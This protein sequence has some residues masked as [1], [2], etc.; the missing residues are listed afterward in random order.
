MILWWLIIYKHIKIVIF[1]VLLL[2]GNNNTKFGRWLFL[3]SLFTGKNVPTC[4][5]TFYIILTISL[6]PKRPCWK[7][8]HKGRHQYASFILGLIETWMVGT[9]CDSGWL[10]KMDRICEYEEGLK[11]FWYFHSWG[12]FLMHAVQTFISVFG[13]NGVQIYSCHIS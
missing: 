12:C 4:V 10:T 11:F 7:K 1:Q 2:N 5:L 8:D 6:C 13:K 9:V 3:V